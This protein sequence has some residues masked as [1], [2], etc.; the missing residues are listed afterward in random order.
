MT[1]MSCLSQRQTGWNPER[2]SQAESAG[3]G[4]RTRIEKGQQRPLHQSRQS[5]R[6]VAADLRV[7]FSRHRCSQQVGQAG[8]DPAGAARRRSRS[9]LQKYYRKVYCLHP[10][11]L[12]LIDH[13]K[14]IRKAKEESAWRDRHHAGLERTRGASTGAHF[15]TWPIRPAWRSG[16]SGTPPFLP[17]FPADAPPRPTRIGAVVDI[18]RSPADRPRRRQSF[19]AA[20]FGTGL[21]K[22]SEDF[23]SQGEPP[24]H[25][26]LLDWLAVDFRENGWDVKRLIQHDRDVRRVPPKSRT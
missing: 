2:P 22:T 16:R 24:S 4:I 11:W 13:E 5:Q 8:S 3:P 15:E 18:A 1:D 23:G 7:S 14:G 9:A 12:A 19:L 20:S 21:V 17:S 26:E 6:T 10:D 25:P